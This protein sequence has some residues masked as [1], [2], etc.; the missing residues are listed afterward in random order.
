M[1]D[2]LTVEDPDWLKNATSDPGF[3]LRTT[4]EIIRTYCGWHIAPSI[5]ETRERLEVGSHGLIMLPSLH[6]TDV[7]SVVLNGQVLDPTS[8][9]W[10]HQGFLKPLRDTAYQSAWGYY[11]EAGPVFLPSTENLLAD[12]T[13]THGYETV[14]ADVKAVAYELAG[15][16]SQTPAVGGSVREIASPGFRLVTGGEN[17]IGMSLSTGQKNRLASY[18]IGGV[19]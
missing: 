11:Y 6:V 18:R 19:R 14:P 9:T 15:W 17:D 7:S 8:Y 2:L 5:T 13:F 1:Q 16:A 12:V 4:G 3:L 10:F